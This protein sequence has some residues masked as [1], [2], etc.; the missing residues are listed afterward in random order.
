M[1]NLAELKTLIQEGTQRI[2]RH[3]MS[4]DWDAAVEES[5]Q[6]LMNLQ[7]LVATAMPAN[8]DELRMLLHEVKLDDT[9]L[10]SLIT[11][12]RLTVQQ[13]LQLQQ[14]TLTAR[15]VYQQHGAR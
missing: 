8:V 3:T 5:R 9:V 10:M 14:R 15:R 4:K 13:Q 6:R 7:R 12:Q 2:R 1:E 11:H